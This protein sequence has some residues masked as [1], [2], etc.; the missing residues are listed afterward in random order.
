MNSLLITLP[1]SGFYE[2][3]H[4]ELIDD[5]IE[6]MLQNDQGNISEN[7]GMDIYHE[8]DY[9]SI[10]HEYAK[11]YVNN[12]NY[13]IQ[14][15]TELNPGFQFESLNRPREYNFTTDRIFAYI[16]AYVLFK[17]IEQIKIEVLEKVIKDRFS[18][19]SG[20]IPFSCYSINVEDW[21]DIPLNEMDHNHLNTLL[22]AWCISTDFTINESDLCY[23]Y[24]KSDCGVEDIICKS[25]QS[26][27]FFKI[28]DKCYQIN[29][30]E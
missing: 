29:Y 9:G 14:N 28:V 19:R 5:S 30:G 24:I 4:D 6:Q 26:D 10:Y 16:P 13:Y 22:E 7:A 20:F 17:M 23:D 18:P 15:E 21:L 2:S 1:F 25:G 12:L 27:E 11:E 3:I 8:T